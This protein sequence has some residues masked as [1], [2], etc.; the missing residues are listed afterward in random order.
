LTT[1]AVLVY[2]IRDLSTSPHHPLGEF[3]DVF[4]GRE[5]AERFS[6]DVRREP[7]LA[8]PPRIE[9][10]ESETGAY[11][12]GKRRPGWRLFP[13]L[14]WGIGESRHVAPQGTQNED[15]PTVWKRAKTMFRPSGDHWALVGVRGC[16][17]L[18]A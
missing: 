8:K 12:P 11:L 10:R 9:E 15:V 2:G 1:P 13:D 4:L 7:E 18:P 17:C 5:D 3:I 14:S 6:E 16:H